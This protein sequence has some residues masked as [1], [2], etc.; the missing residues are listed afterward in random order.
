MLVCESCRCAFSAAWSS[1]ARFCRRCLASYQRLM[2]QRQRQLDWVNAQ[3]EALHQQHVAHNAEQA[4]LKTAAFKVRVGKFTDYP[5]SVSGPL[6]LQPGEALAEME[7]ELL[8]AYGRLTPREWWALGAEAKAG[9][10]LGDGGEMGA[11]RDQGG[12]LA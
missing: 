1:S 11:E 10:E 2:E 9:G 6:R 8:R 4:A 7:R 5:G 12:E 3:M